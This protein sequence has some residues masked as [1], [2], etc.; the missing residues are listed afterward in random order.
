VNILKST[1]IVRNVDDL[2][3][4]VLPIEMR[5]TMN[6]DPK[7]PVEIYV[8]EGR[9][10]FKKYESGCHFCGSLEGNEYYKEKLVCKTCVEE[11]KEVIS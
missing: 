8:E 6:I 7:D 10:I 3:R 4:V 5:K 9:I 11:L 2:G 1:G